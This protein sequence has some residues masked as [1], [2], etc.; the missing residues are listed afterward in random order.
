MAGPYKDE[1]QKAIQLEYDTLMERNTWELVA[2]PP[3]RQAIGVKWLL[4]VKTN[5][6]GELE[7]FKARLVA[8]VT[9]RSRA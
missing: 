1:W 2:L 4:K 3:G 6:K 5:A 8:K 9:H 7:K